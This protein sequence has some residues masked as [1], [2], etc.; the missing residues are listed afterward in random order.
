MLERYLGHLSEYVIKK[1]K[2]VLDSGTYPSTTKKKTCVVPGYLFEYNE[3]NVC[4][5][6]VPHST[7]P[8]YGVYH[9][10]VGRFSA[11]DVSTVGILPE[12]QGSALETTR[13]EFSELVSFGVG[14]LLTV[15]QPGAWKHRPR[16]Q[17]VCV[18]DIC[19]VVYGTDASTP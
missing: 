3:N 16:G 6:R 1:K 7:Y 2:R 5:T 15:E 10:H 8:V 11:L 13:R 4:G 12:P 17:G 19:A 14:T 18:C 9:T